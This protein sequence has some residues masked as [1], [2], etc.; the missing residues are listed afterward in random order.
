MLLDELVAAGFTAAMRDRFAYLDAEYVSFGPLVPMA[1]FE[2]TGYVSSFPQLIDGVSVFTG[3]DR[4]HRA[5]LAARDRGERWQDQLTSA[6]LMMVSACCHPLYAMLRGQ[7]VDGQAYGVG[8]PGGFAFRHE[9]SKDPFRAVTF[10]QMEHVVFGDEA[11]ASRTRD[12]CVQTAF[13]LLTVLGL[14]PRAEVASDPFFGRAGQL[15]GSGQQATSAKIELT[16]DAYGPDCERVGLGSGNKHGGHFCHDFG[17]TLASGEP[18][19]SMCMGFGLE[20]VA[21]ALLQTH[22]MSVGSWPIDVRELLDL[23]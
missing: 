6:G 8:G 20:R 15:M 12:R 17:L 4:D 5:L 1:A 16:Y 22:G 9:P 3:D 2:F 23:A 19:H 10:R 18:A 14:D 13:D 11:H 7:Q 21:V